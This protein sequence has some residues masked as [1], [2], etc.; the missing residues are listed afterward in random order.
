MGIT[1]KEGFREMTLDMAEVLKV[2][3]HPA[4]LAIME[5]LA[6]SPSCICND[7]VGS[8]P[9]AQP[10]VSR[11]L[12][13]LKRVGLIKGEISGKNICYCIDNDRWHMVMDYLRKLT[14]AIEAPV[15]NCNSS[16]I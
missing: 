8:V 13:E 2:L 10:T 3:G 7:V 4:R 5:F 15:A 12:S 11:H 16:I 9:L 6:E 14:G 1:K